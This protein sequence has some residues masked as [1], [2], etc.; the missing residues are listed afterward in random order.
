[1]VGKSTTVLAA[2]MGAVVLLALVACA[3]IAGLLLTHAVARGRE[4]AIRGAL[5]ASRSRVVRQLLTGTPASFHG[6]FFDLDDAV[7]APAPATAIPMVVGGRSDVAIRRAGRLGDG[8]L[9]IWNSPRRF[10]DAVEMA[11]PETRNPISRRVSP[12]RSNPSEILSP[13]SGL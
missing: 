6:K 1:M 10:A 3:N 2:M 5:G 9:G 13:Q 4:L 7:I 8:W 12:S 11:Q